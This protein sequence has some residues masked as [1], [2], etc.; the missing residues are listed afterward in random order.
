MARRKAR[1]GRKIQP[2]PTTLTFDLGSTAPASAGPGVT[3]T[4]QT[5]YIDLS[6]CASLVARKFLRQGMVWGV[7]GMKL[8]SVNVVSGTDS[9]VADSPEGSIMVSKLPTSWVMSNAWEKS[10]RV[11]Q[12]MNNEALEEAESVKPKFLDFKVFMD[13]GHHQAGPSNNLLPVVG[14]QFAWTPASAGEWEYSKMIIPITE[15]DAGAG[16][17]AER[18]LI[19]VGASYPGTSAATGN[20]AVSLIEGYAASRGLPDIRDPN[21]PDD[22][23]DTLGGTPENWMAATFNEGIPQDHEVIEDMITENNRAPYPF[24]NDGINADTMYPGGANQLAGVEV[25]SIE[26]IT[27]STVGGVTYLQGNTFPCGLIKIDVFNNDDTFDLYNVL[28]IE[29][30]PGPAR[31][32]MALPMTEM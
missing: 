10:F 13:S 9:P 1:R 23:D 32:Y 28:Q 14:Q 21:T 4:Q 20:N 31:G 22:A 5:Y 19:A 29:L 8:N 2:V 15:P 7:S 26:N 27:G 12:R 24:E 16:T 3:P 6:Q 17:T 30:S 25:A 18:D 11:W